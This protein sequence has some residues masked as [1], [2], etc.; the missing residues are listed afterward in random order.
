[1]LKLRRLFVYSIILVHGLLSISRTIAI[2]D[3]YSAPIRLLVDSKTR[4]TFDEQTSNEIRVCIGKDWYR[5]P[6]HFLLPSKFVCLFL[7]LNENQ[8]QKFR[9]ELSFIRSEFRGQLP[10]AY[11]QLKN[12]TRLVENH[13]NDENKEE[14]DRYVCLFFFVLQKRNRIDWFVCKLG[15]TRSM[16]F[17]NRSW[18]WTSNWSRTK[19]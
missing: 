1:V 6:S 11:S 12:A 18:Q 2:V 5:F 17:L 3:G 14:I 15:W 7:C 8:I 4:Q 13:F 9:C 16:W 10:K 19:L